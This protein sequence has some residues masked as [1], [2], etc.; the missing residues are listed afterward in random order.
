[1]GVLILSEAD[2][3]SVLTMDL[4]LPAVEAAFRKLSLDEATNIPRSR[5]QTDHV[6]MHVL[7]AAAK[8][9]NAL[10]HKTYTT[11]TFGAKFYVTLYDPKTGDPTAILHADYLGQ[12]RTGAATGVATKKLA[13]TDAKTVGI[14]GAGKQARTQL[15]AVAKVRPLISAVVYS[16]SAASRESFAKEMSATIG[17]PVTAVDSAEEAARNKD[18]ICTATNA[19]EPVL[20][21]EWLAAGCHLNL[22]GSNFLSKAEA[23]VDVFRRASLIACD[24]KDQAKL[25]AGDF[26]KAMN[27]GVFGWSDAVELSHILT[28]RYPGRAG[29]NDITV[30]KSLG[31]GIQDIAVAVKVVEASRAKGIGQ[32]VDF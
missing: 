23:D 25:E 17:I 11:G 4:A 19:R 21:G 29:A 5:C 24:S 15:E 12:V 10:G 26:V 16:Q 7:P 32:E 8:T 28:G 9:L 30:F 27:E 2:V 13:R 20:K 6:M 31:L 1:M 22:A 14:I 18:I 3:K